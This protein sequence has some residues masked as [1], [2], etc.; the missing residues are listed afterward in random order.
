[1]YSSKKEKRKQ[2]QQAARDERLA[3]EESAY[4]PSSASQ[5]KDAEDSE[6]M[7]EKTYPIVSVLSEMQDTM[8]KL[9][10][11]MNNMADRVDRLEQ[12][13]NSALKSKNRDKANKANGSSSPS[14]DSQQ[15]DESNNVAR[16]KKRKD[17]PKKRYSTLE[18]LQ[19]RRESAQK[20]LSYSSDKE[21]DPSDSSSDESS[22]ASPTKPKKAA[23]KLF[24]DI[25]HSTDV[26]SAQ[27]VLVMRKEKECHVTINKFRLSK[28]A[29]AIRD[30]INFQEEEGTVVRMQ[31]VLSSDMK[32]HLRVS[33]GLTRTDLA[34][35]DMSD[36]FQIIAEETKVYSTVAFYDE[37]KD[38]MSH[39]K[40]MD[41]SK[42]SAVNHEVFYFQ[43]LKFIDNFKR[44]LQIMLECNK[45]Y[46]P[47][48]DD[49]QY[50]LVRLF[51]E[52]NDPAYIAY[53]FGCMKTL[54]F[55]TMNEFFNEFS[56]VL[57]DHYQVS[58][59]S[60]ELPYR[61]NKEHKDRIKD[62]YERKRQDSFVKKSSHKDQKKTFHRVSH[63]REKD[64]DSDEYPDLDEVS[65]VEDLVSDC[66]SLDSGEEPVEEESKTSAS[67]PQETSENTESED[68][69]A[70]VQQTQGAKTQTKYGCMKKMLYGKCDKFNCKYSHDDSVVRQ[71]ARELRDK[72]D[73]YLRSNPGPDNRSNHPPVLRRNDVADQRA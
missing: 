12:I 45:E 3:A 66:V 16:R 43:Q 28:V 58:L 39:T 68:M 52:L 11:G 14:S 48:V 33:R 34:K 56:K 40:I 27:T 50:G 35:L 41:W 6:T 67:K 72:V 17:K 36:L 23:G 25:K 15:E 51:K 57:Y 42:V 62:Y 19:A 65:S 24:R 47:R 71:S 70:A 55:N 1:M 73:A 49:K 29:K 20:R 44:M 60:R 13:N 46:C 30:I 22:Q 21:S 2:A 63:L 8:Q 18:D 64:S 53:A 7:G 61:T 69:L 32:E 5:W 37:L 10:Q 31:K 54:S 26:A 9:L 59:V 4:S 38:A